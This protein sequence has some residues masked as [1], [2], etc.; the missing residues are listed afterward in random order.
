VFSEACEGLVIRLVIIAPG[1]RADFRAAFIV[2]VREESYDMV[3]DSTQG[4]PKFDGKS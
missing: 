3:I 2:R 1:I 4:R